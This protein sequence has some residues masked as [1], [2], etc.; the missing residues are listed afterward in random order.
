MDDRLENLMDAYD[1]EELDAI[2]Y[3]VEYY[4]V[5]DDVKNAINKLSNYKIQDYTH[6]LYTLSN[7]YIDE[8]VKSILKD[9]IFYTYLENIF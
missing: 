4:M 5:D 9:K 1:L 8:T 3:I 6:Y 2:K 7:M